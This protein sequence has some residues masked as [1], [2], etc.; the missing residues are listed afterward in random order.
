MDFRGRFQG[1]ETD[2]GSGGRVSPCGATSRGYLLLLPILALLSGCGRQ[3]SEAVIALNGTT[4]DR[5]FSE[6]IAD[7][8]AALPTPVRLVVFD[9]QPGNMA[10]APAVEEARRVVAMEG[11]V[12]VVGHRDSR[13]TMVMGPIYQDAGLPLVV[14]TAT[15]SSIDSLGPAVFRMVPDD[16]EEGL[17]LASLVTDSLQARRVSIFHWADEYGVGIKDGFLEGLEGSGV[18]VL[19][20]V[21]YVPRRMVCPDEYQ[22]RVDASLLKGHPEIVVLGSRW[23]DA[24]CWIRLLAERLP[25]V[26]FLG[27]DGMSP[28]QRLMERGGQGTE[29]L[30]IVQFW[31]EDLA[32]EREEAFLRDYRVASGGRMDEGTVLRWDAVALLVE[33]VQ[34][35]GPDREKVSQHLRA[36]GNQ[37]PPFLGM[38]GPVSFAPEAERPM[39]LV[40]VMGRPRPLWRH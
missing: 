35:V 37:R 34:T 5:L 12:A 36:L 7:S 10:W 16:R 2:A 40:D 30:R 31:A 18:E 4:P 13:S 6:A 19:D 11:L 25:D 38:S 22:P 26:V 39:V 32:D 20:V 29:R 21:E 28:G 17:F 1:A 15:A 8:L 9:P 23:E 33:A 24:A 27:A 14:P 3:P